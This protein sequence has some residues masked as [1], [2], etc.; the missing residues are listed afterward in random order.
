MSGQ[1]PDLGLFKV[2]CELDRAWVLDRPVCIFRGLGAIDIKMKRL[3]LAACLLPHAGVYAQNG[4]GTIGSASPFSISGYAEPYYSYAFDQSLND[5]KPSFIYSYN[6]NDEVAVNLAFL[7]ASY[8]TRNIRANFALAAGSYVNANYSAEPGVV[9]NLYQGNVGIKLSRENNLWLDVGVFPS[10]IGFE[11]PVGKDNWTLTRSLGA[12]NTPYFESGARVSYTSENKTWFVSGLILNGW[13][14]IKPVPGNSTPSFGTQI[15]YRPSP[16]ITL[17]SSTFIGN[18]YPDATRR[19]R[20]FHNFYGIFQLNRQ[21]AALIGF[22]IGMEQK[23]KGSSAMN[24][25]FNPTVI[26][27]YA[28]TEKTAI[29]VKAEYYDD[30]NGVRIATGTPHGFKTW[31]FSANFDYYL[32]PNILWRVEARTLTR[33]FHK[34]A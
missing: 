13:Q 29:A 14:H 30:R 21:L 26:L 2:V 15:T 17:N 33:M 19:M 20:Y 32:S 25:W 27:R 23:H 22:D 11:S 24:T 4:I 1:L 34:F 28:P 31:S 8:N 3:I 18:D 9:K 12:D 10:H 7:K 16:G 6:K 5:T